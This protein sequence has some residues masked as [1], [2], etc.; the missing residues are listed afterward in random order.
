M[1]LLL[2]WCFCYW[3]RWC[4]IWWQ[5]ADDGRWLGRFHPHGKRGVFEHDVMAAFSFCCFCPC[6][7]LLSFVVD[8][9]LVWL[10]FSCSSSSP[11]IR[12]RCH[13]TWKC[14]LAVLIRQ[15]RWFFCGTL[16]NFVAPPAVYCHALSALHCCLCQRLG[17]TLC[18]FDDNDDDEGW[19][20]Q[21]MM[22]ISSASG[23][24]SAGFDIVIYPF[25]CALI[26]ILLL[27]SLLVRWRCRSA[28]FV[29]A[30][31]WGL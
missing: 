4:W 31:W 12:Y 5:C 18:S 14:S 29:V 24:G 2:L 6:R 27:L 15:R 21:T 20:W 13:T 17:R 1:L 28:I 9:F 16:G 19:C 30:I 3:R 8:D 25:H 11:F 10:P 22:L 7:F 26:L 23:G